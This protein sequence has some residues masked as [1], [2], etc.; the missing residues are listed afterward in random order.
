MRI[1]GL[2]AATGLPVATLKYYLREGLLP[3]G[4]PTAVNQ[5]DYDEGHLRRARLVRALLELGRLPLADIKRVLEAVDDE[6]IGLHDAFGI[7]Q[8]AMVPPRDRSDEAHRRALDDV[9]VF[10]RRHRL[11]VREDAQVRGMLADALVAMRSGGWDIDLSAFDERMPE[12]TAQ[13]AAELGQLPA[14]DRTTQME[15][16]VIGTIGWEV[17][18]AALRR[19]A[20]EDASWR[21]FG[22]RRGVGS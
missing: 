9:D 1:A 6:S 17:A 8:D 22:R 12:V 20:L 11:H 18:T 21:R 14:E 3:P 16:T 2:S 15:G 7:A 4:T 5:A 19:I 13:A 10:L